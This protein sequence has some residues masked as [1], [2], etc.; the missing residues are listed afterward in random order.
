MVSPLP[1]G[2]VCVT[3]EG[4]LL[5]QTAHTKCQVAGGEDEEDYPEDTQGDT[6]RTLTLMVVSQQAGPRG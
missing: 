2:E 6:Q 3:E 5:L 4:E 1:Q